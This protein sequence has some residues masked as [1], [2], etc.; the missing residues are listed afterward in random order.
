MAQL[1]RFLGPKRNGN[2]A[3]RFYLSEVPQL[4]DCDPLP[5]EGIW[6][7]L[8]IFFCCQNCGGGGAVWLPVGGG[9][10]RLLN[11]LPHTQQ[12]P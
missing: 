9:L 3:A 11:T 7:Y 1:R 5:P 8:E 6:Q 12:P 10:V 2:R 4:V